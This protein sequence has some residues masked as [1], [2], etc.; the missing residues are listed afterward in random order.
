MKTSLRKRVGQTY[1]WKLLMD[2]ATTD[3]CQSIKA[4]YELSYQ[5]QVNFKV[6]PIT[7]NFY[8]EIT[9]PQQVGMLR[10]FDF[11][12]IT[13][14]GDWGERVRNFSEIVQDLNQIYS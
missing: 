9:N 11:V 13:K 12:Y 6:G 8:Q 10:F 7:T 4:K 14:A 1:K 2:I 5:A 3:D